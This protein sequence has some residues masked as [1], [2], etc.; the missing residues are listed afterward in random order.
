MLKFKYEVQ[1]RGGEEVLNECM[2]LTWDGYGHIKD[3]LGM[4]IPLHG[5][6]GNVGC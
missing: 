5:P 3:P 1:I 4:V 2:L 6:C